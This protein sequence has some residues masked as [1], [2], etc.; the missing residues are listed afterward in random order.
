MTAEAKNAEA[1][2]AAEGAEG[3]G[4]GGFAFLVVGKLGNK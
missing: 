2:R 4:E 1:P 3:A